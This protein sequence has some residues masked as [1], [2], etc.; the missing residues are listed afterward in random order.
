LIEKHEKQKKERLGLNGRKRAAEATSADAAGAS[1]GSM[2]LACF[3]LLVW[4]T[5]QNHAP[6]LVLLGATLL[7]ISLSV[8]LWQIRKR[9]AIYRRRNRRKRSTPGQATISPTTE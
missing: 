1:I 5:I 9:L 4:K 2:A 6:W 3:A 7:W 8:L